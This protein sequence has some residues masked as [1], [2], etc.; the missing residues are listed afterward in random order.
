[1]RRIVLLTILCLPLTAIGGFYNVQTYTLNPGC[2]PDVPETSKVEFLKFAKE[3]GWE[4]EETVLYPIH[5]ESLSPSHVVVVDS[6]PNVSAFGKQMD[7]A[8]E[9]FMANPQG[10]W[11]KF[12]AGINKCFTLVSQTS[13]GSAD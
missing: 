2:A 13:Y 1:M 3:K 11:A 7:Q 6:Y 5:G 10:E 8:F 9:E 12:I 4:V